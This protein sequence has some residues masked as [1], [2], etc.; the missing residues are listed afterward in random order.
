MIPGQK[1]KDCR[2][3]K[4]S[5]ECV[6]ESISLMLRLCI[7]SFVVSTQKETTADVL[8]P[9]VAVTEPKPGR[10]QRTEQYWRLEVQNQGVSWRAHQPRG[11]LLPECL[12][13]VFPPCVSAQTSLSW[14]H[15]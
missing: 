13:L 12:H 8:G 10:L 5:C 2:V 4:G 9:G 7:Q 15:Q 14:G 3:E 11:S 1:Q 6:E